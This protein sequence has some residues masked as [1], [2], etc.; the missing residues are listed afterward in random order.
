MRS[1]HKTRNKQ[2]AMEPQN[3]GTMACLH[4]VAF[5]FFKQNKFFFLH[6][7]FKI[8]Y[9]AENRKSNIAD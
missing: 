9:S 1:L 5:F 3:Q 6:T 4:V 7:C 2:Q 8:R